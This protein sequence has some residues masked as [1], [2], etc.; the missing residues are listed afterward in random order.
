MTVRT[1]RVFALLV[2]L[3]ATAL[4]PATAQALPSDERLGCLSGAT[5]LGPPPGSSACSL[6]PGAQANGT[7]SGLEGIAA[8]LVSPDG[9]NVYALGFASVLTF[10]RDPATGAVSFSGCISGEQNPADPCTEI[11]GATENGSGSGL[12]NASDVAIS[13]D[14][15]NLYVAASSDASVATFSRNTTSGALSFI[16]C[17]SGE[18]G[19]CG[20][21]LNG[22]NPITRTPNGLGSGFNSASGIAVHPNDQA[23]FSTSPGDDA[24]T[25]FVRNPDGRL[26]YAGCFTGDTGAGSGGSGACN[27]S[28]QGTTAF[29]IDSGFNGVNSLA[30][31]PDGLNFYATA[32]SDSSLIAFAA[33]GGGALEFERCV[34]G[35][36]GGSGSD[37][38]DKCLDLDAGAGAAVPLAT[39]DGEDSPLD[40]P[41]S[42]VVSPD[43]LDLY[44]NS[45]DYGI[46]HFSRGLPPPDAQK[47]APL[48]FSCLSGLSGH[49]PLP[50]A[51][52]RRPGTTGV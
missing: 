36:K 42:V 14:G 31:S 1:R 26:A 32:R 33:G 24:I 40:S 49:C 41:T 15:E 12:G 10:D 38:N 25:A 13:G 46:A 43:G 9:R 22:G 47:G 4:I 8:P 52:H 44:V 29:G 19:T 28:P 6:T 5:Q 35:D 21:P 3:A 30:F 20:N 11:P 18:T 2:A 51:R 27:D 50:A 45:L 7:N 37:G 34:T 17:H 39:T 48:F 16:E 23:V